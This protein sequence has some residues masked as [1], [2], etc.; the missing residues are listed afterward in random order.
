[1]EPGGSGHDGDYI[2]VFQVWRPSPSVELDG[3]Y[4]LVESD[5]Y[6]NIPLEG[7][8]LVTRDVPSSTVM[9]VQPGDVVGYFISSTQGEGRDEGIQLE[10]RDAENGERVW[11]HPPSSGP[12]MI[13]K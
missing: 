5:A 2:I 12:L 7:G 4:S 9:S 6:T 3:C 13:K 10:R 11:H 8:G 1:M